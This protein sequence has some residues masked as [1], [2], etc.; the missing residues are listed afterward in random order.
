MTVHKE[1]R[2]TSISIIVVLHDSLNLFEHP[3]SS[4]PLSPRAT[5]LHT[6]E[7][8]CPVEGKPCLGNGE[9]IRLVL[10]CYALAL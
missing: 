3:L 10:P 4:Q 6:F 5:H 7:S 2:F 8:A 9:V 1:V